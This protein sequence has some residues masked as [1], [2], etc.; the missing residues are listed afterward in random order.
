MVWIVNAGFLGNIFKS[1]VAA[2]AEQVIGF[3]WKATGPALHHNASIPA[4]LIVAAKL[5][6]M[7]DINENVSWDKHVDKPIAIVVCPGRAGV[8]SWNAKAGL[9]SH[10]FKLAVP[11]ISIEG[12]A[13]ETGNKNVLPAVVV[14]VH[15]GNGHSPTFAR[16]PR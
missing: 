4:E 10:V 15:D 7:V 3:S 14:I 13:A 8:E 5:R 1:A 9:F 12:I 2:I 11:Q 16:K 6:Q